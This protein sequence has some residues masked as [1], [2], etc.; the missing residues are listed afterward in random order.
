[1]VINCH[2]SGSYTL[3]GSARYHNVR[4]I[5]RQAGTTKVGS[6][7]T[8]TRDAAGTYTLATDAYGRTVLTFTVSDWLMYV[9]GANLV[10]NSSK[11]AVSGT[12]ATIDSAYT[13]TNGNIV[14]ADEA[15]QHVTVGFDRWDL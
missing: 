15:N 8:V 5:L 14:F 7:A 11:I 1:V 10:V 13:V 6:N 4:A 2:P 9:S 12:N 3:N